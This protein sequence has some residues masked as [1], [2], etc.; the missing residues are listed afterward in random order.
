MDMGTR[1]PRLRV[2]EVLGRN[3]L[4]L[5]NQIGCQDINGGG[6]LMEHFLQGSAAL[7]P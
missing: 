5:S 6:A 3:Q 7:R 2:M 4:L 1:I